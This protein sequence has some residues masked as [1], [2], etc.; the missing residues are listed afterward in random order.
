MA[1]MITRNL[2][3]MIVM[4]SA[5]VMY[6][7]TV[8]AQDIVSSSNEVQTNI[9]YRRIAIK[10][11]QQEVARRQAVMQQKAKDM[12]LSLPNNEKLYDE[13]DVS[14]RTSLVEAGDKDGQ[15][16]YTFEISYNCKHIDGQTDDYPAGA[17]NYTE[18]N[19]CRAICTLTKQFLENDCSDIFV[20][21][22]KLLVKI[23][24]STDATTVSE[25]PYKG[26][27]G[28]FRYCQVFYNDQP[29]RVSVNM[30]EGIVSNAQLAFLRG[31]SVKS[32]LESAVENL[33]N[34]V[35][36]YEFYTK[37]YEMTGA[38][39]RRCS[40]EITVYDA[41]SDKL[42]SML[43]TLEAEDP[44][45]DINIPVNPTDNT[46]TYALIIVNDRYDTL[47]PNVPYAYNDANIFK[48]YCLKTLGIPERQLKV[49]RNV[50]KAKISSS[51]VKWLQ[52]LMRVA[53]GK[54]KILV[55][56]A[57]YG[58]LDANNAPY[59]LPV[60][61]CIPV[62]GGALGKKPLSN[63]NRVRLVQ[64]GLAVSEFCSMLTSVQTQSVTLIMDAN[65]NGIQ[66]DGE[67]LFP[68][69]EKKCGSKSKSKKK[70]KALRI[71]G[72]AVVFCSSDFTATSYAFK[73]QEHGFFTYFL[74][75]E[76]KR[77]KGNI[78]YDDM[79]TNVKEAVSIESSLQ[80]LQQIPYMIAGGKTKD[81]W[82][83]MSFR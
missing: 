42:K 18:S 58:V 59:I 81:T 33:R 70:T 41:F 10:N 48:E 23:T 32:Y 74:L 21:G 66:R 15:L 17:Y 45:V 76:L 52:D 43:A 61:A 12:L 20:S 56:Y 46:N 34:T 7:S 49:L 75:K 68:P 16:N 9:R 14:I 47:F 57:G 6:C 13:G 22:K 65:F 50:N 25:V 53:R 24:S 54:G 30:T 80:G 71:R 62:K 1:K 8:A 55:Y 5:V 37:S 67:N 36:T 51:G 63:K 39:Y 60:D 40:I 79:F 83:T 4:L 2:K 28:D 64:Q 82:N 11:L 72:D 38:Q 19:S 31:Q 78:S 27:Y 3:L 26:E 44:N 69:K 35:N 77:T 29:T 73:D